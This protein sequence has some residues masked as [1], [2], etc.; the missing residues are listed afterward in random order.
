MHEQIC[1]FDRECPGEVITGLLERY[2]IRPKAKTSAPAALAPAP[3]E[4]DAEIGGKVEQL[5]AVWAMADLELVERAKHSKNGTQF[6]ALWAGDTTGYKSHSEADVALCNALVFWTNKDVGRVDRL[7]RQSGLFRPEKWDRATADS[8]YGAITI[9]NAIATAR[10]GYDPE[11]YQ[12]VQAEHQRSN[13]EGQNIDQLLAL[14]KPLE[15]FPEEEAKWLIPGWIPEGQISVIA[16]DGGIGKT[17]L[18]CHVIA[19]LSN[20]STC[21]LDPPGHTREPMRITFLTTEDSVRKK[22]RKKLRLA[23]ANMKNIITPDFVGD[24]S[25]LLR[26][27]K[28]GTPEMDKVLRHLQPV[29]CVFDPVQ[30]FTPPKVNMG[31]RNEMRDCLA[32]LISIG[33]DINTTA[34]IVCHTNKRPKAS[35]R[36]RIADSADL[37]DIARS[38]LMAGFTEEQG[39]RYLSNEKNNYGPLQE[40]IL[41]TIDADGQIH[42]VGTSWKRDREYIMGAEQA[43]SAPARE[44][45]MA[46]IVKTLNEAGGTMPTAEL[47]KK[48]ELAGYSFSAI[49]RAK[50]SLK[51][52]RKAR[53]FQTGSTRKGDNVWHIQLLTA[54]ED[55]FEELPDGTPTPFDNDNPR[56]TVLSGLE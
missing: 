13:G 50:S 35:G 56:Q 38:V 16:A 37:W 11:A 41:F 23:G 42:K 45:C 18:W 55:A 54:P 19:A 24:R 51:A 47:D 31:S 27:L 53:F 48:A 17:T 26:N 39:V 12:G 29:L 44:D 15:D 30:G 43:K 25:G 20:G 46:F 49:R 36:E 28:F 33:E 8:T 4:W 6:A 40:T 32:P 10:Q 5:P 1:N 3:M 14:F 7:F 52:E 34:L 9:Q 21:I 22:L 2:M